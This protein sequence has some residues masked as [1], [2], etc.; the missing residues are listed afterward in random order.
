MISRL[1]CENG[2]KFEKNKTFETCK[3]PSGVYAK[4]DFYINDE[5]LLECDG[6]CHEKGWMNHLKNTKERDELKNKWCKENGIT[7]LRVPYRKGQEIKF[8]DLIPETSKYV[9]R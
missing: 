9:V 3:M 8:E 7:L 5:Y 2:I 6:V 1:L 4:F